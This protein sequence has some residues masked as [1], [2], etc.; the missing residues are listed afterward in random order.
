LRQVG[1]E[2]V[3]LKH[4]DP[5]EIEAAWLYVDRGYWGDIE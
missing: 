4:V 3:S 1:D 2:L 5:G